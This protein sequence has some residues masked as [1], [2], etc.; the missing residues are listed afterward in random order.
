M[1]I[2]EAP[3]PRDHAGGLGPVLVR[4]PCGDR[5]AGLLGVPA[6][7]RTRRGLGPYRLIVGI[8]DDLAAR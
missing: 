2:D 6:G 5:V 4:E 8:T 7:D 3:L 1:G